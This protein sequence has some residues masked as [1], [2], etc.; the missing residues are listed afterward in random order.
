VEI[1][2][3]ASIG[4]YLWIHILNAQKP[5]GK[6]RKLGSHSYGLLNFIYRGG[7]GFIQT[8]VPQDVEYLVIVL[9]GRTQ[10]DV[11]KSKLWIDYLPRLEKLKK[12]AI[13]LLG[14][15]QCDNDWIKP[16]MRSNGGL[17][18]VLFLVYDSPVVN[19]NDVYQWPLGVATYRN[20]PLLE[21]TS[22]NIA[23][24]RT[25]KCNFVG[26]IYENSTREV[27]IDSLSK[28]KGQCFVDVRYKW[29]PMETEHSLKR[30]LSTLMKS[31]L[32]LSPVGKNPEC[33]R[34]YEALSCG[35]VPIIEDKIM[36]GSCSSPFRLLK[37]YK[38]PVIFINKWE[39]LIPILTSEH[40]RP[41]FEIVG[42]RK[43]VISWY[44]HFRSTMA[45]LFAKT[46]RKK[47]FED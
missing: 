3:K 25:Y 17:V 33:Y 16:Y 26:T 42:R 24:N 27:M 14:N 32:T 30:Y 12:T 19:N 34:I 47:F 35:S 5:K 9:N 20:F 11:K 6:F 39:E 4:D 44:T 15:E 29:L 13:M 18:D 46:I 41:F 45:R 31:D 21:E 38:A 10:N 8:T 7:P 2:A 37:E 36:T 22:V 1:W 23:N 40:K 43:K 28:Y